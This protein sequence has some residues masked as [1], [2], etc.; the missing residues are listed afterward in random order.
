MPAL[1]AVESEH[2]VHLSQP[3]VDTTLEQRRIVAPLAPTMSNQG[4]TH[5]VCHAI[6][7]K[8]EN[9]P[10][11]LVHGEPVQIQAGI[12]QVF[13]LAQIF[14]NA[15][16]DAIPLP[17]QLIPG[18]DRFD[19]LDIVQK[20]DAPGRS[21]LGSASTFQGT[22]GRLAGSEPAG[23]GFPLQGFYLAHELPEQL[24][25]ILAHGERLTV[26]APSGNSC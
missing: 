4:A 22:G 8:L 7:N 24:T 10:A 6:V 25:V 19:P 26:T 5:I 21:L 9:G 14:E 1:G 12:G 17:G 16:L 2:R 3:V 15:V 20:I 18:L 23:G 11:R 13:A